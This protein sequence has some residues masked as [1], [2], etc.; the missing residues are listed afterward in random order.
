MF[1]GGEYNVAAVLRAAAFERGLVVPLIGG[2]GMNDPAYVSGAGFASG[3]SYASGV[4]LPLEAL[5][6]ADE[7]LAAYRAV[8]NTSDPTD[9]GPYAY[10]AANSVIDVLAEQLGGKKS[11]PTSIRAAVVSGLQATD[12]AGLTGQVGFDEFGDPLDPRFTLYRV[13]GSPLSW[14]ALPAG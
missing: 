1:F 11:L 4:G 8:G 12:R 9:Y 2:D 7:F 5:A 3:D 10:D 6:G 13:G 14:T